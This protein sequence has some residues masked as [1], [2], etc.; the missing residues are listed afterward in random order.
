MPGARGKPTDAVADHPASN[1][2]SS[3]GGDPVRVL[4]TG[5]SSTTH[6]ALAGKGT[7]IAEQCIAATEEV[8]K[9]LPDSLP[10]FCR[11]VVVGG[12]ASGLSTAACLRMRGEE[13]V[14]VLE[15]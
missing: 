6:E 8:A 14:I 13:D 3:I 1:Q 4:H 2:R 11:V 7:S 5:R 9:G 10:G 15:R 12:G